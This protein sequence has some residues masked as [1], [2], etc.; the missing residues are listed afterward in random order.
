M[1]MKIVRV[2]QRL[3]KLTGRNV[4]A[5]FWRGLC[6]KSVLCEIKLATTCAA[7]LETD[8]FYDEARKETKEGQVLRSSR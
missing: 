5:L 4:K 7:L 3:L 6:A 1:M 8:I 2:S